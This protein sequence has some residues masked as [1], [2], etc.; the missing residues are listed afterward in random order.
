V[1]QSGAAFVES[2]SEEG[3][4]PPA[5]TS[6]GFR[7]TFRSE[8]PTAPSLCLSLPGRMSGWAESSRASFVAR[9]AGKSA[10][11]PALGAQSC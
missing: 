5:L 9:P 10:L 6:R 11:G 8:T 1:L 3:N 4:G 7:L 2:R